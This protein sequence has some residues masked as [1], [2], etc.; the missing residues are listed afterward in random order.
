M[1]GRGEEGEKGKREEGKLA[2]VQHGDTLPLIHPRNLPLTSNFSLPLFSFVLLV[3]S[4]CIPAVTSHPSYS[5]VSKISSA[6]FSSAH[7]VPR[8]SLPPPHPSVSSLTSLL[9]P[10]VHE[11]LGAWEAK[12][13]FSRVSELRSGTTHTHLA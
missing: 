9:L 5:T 13:S 8:F 12:F 7:L 1:E 2:P 6:T 3:S 4:L 10:P 11:S